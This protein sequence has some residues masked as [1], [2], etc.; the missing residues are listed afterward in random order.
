MADEDK[1]YDAGDPRDVRDAIKES[2]RWDDLRDTVIVGVMSSEN[3]R[4]WVRE[5]L[6]HCM[7]GTN[8]FNADPIKM[9]FN[10][11]CVNAGQV[12]MAQVMNADPK[13]Y[14]QMMAEGHPESQEKEEDN[15]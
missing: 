14:M 4:R 3:G 6:E 1:P 5:F 12:F 11:G 15:G 8:P 7:V 2:K 10:C 9:A 13:L